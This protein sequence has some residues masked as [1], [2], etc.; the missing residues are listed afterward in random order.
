M[1][2]VYLISTDKPSRLFLN[3]INNK[4]LLDS[5]NYSDLEKILPSSNYQHLYITNGE[6]IKE[7]DWI[8]WE[9]KVVKAINTSYW[10]AKKIILTTDEQLITDGVQSISDE[11]LQW[12]IQ[13]PNCEEIK[14]ADYGN[15]LFDDK[16][17]HMYKI[18]IPREEQK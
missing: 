3:K 11:F 6:Q 4:L 7:G 1:R 5:D 17:F 16:V 15:V 2:N 9:G 12:F 13:N 14:V 18:V 10:D 8:L